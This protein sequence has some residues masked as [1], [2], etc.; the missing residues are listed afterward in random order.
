[1]GCQEIDVKRK[2]ERMR[3]HNKKLHELPYTEMVNSGTF[4]EQVPIDLSL[5]L[6]Y[7]G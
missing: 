1:M 5:D 3:P 7:A 4:R 2:E 6:E